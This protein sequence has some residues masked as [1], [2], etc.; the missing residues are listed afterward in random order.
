MTR[1]CGAL[2]DILAIFERCFF[3]C[4]AVSAPICLVCGV[5]GGALSTPPVS[6]LL[7]FMLCLAGIGVDEFRTCCDGAVK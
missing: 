5:F 2:L 3:S 4:L 6:S 1:L 7:K